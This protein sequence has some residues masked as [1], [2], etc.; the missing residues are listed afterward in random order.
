[1]SS[2]NGRHPVTKTFTPPTAS[3]RGKI[4]RRVDKNWPGNTRIAQTRLNN[5]GERKGVLFSEL[6]TPT[7]KPINGQRRHFHL[8]KISQG[9]EI[10]FYSPYLYFSRGAKLKIYHH[11]KFISL[12]VA[13][14]TVLDVFSL[15]WSSNYESAIYK[16]LQCMAFSKN[17]ERVVITT[18]SC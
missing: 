14:R 2:N 8:G 18:W 16:I 6:N 7:P 5:L 10:H 11:N 4:W 3:S 1:M 13:M 17:S 9:I 15:F 12:S